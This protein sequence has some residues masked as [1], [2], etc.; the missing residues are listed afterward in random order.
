MI[1]APLIVTM[2]RVAPSAGLD[3]DNAVGSMK[4][5]RDAVAKVLG[6][7]DRS[8]LVDWRVEQ[9]KGPWATEIRIEM[10]PCKT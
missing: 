10:N 2:T 5:V 7:D 9:R 4:H 1:V 8:P 6:I 3:S